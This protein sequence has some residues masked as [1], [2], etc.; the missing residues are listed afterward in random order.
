M[1]V[2]WFM[3]DDMSIDVCNGWKCEYINVC[4]FVCWDDDL[5]FLD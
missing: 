4:V 3:A 2:N 5:H 1:Y